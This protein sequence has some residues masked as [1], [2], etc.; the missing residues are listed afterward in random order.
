MR[1]CVVKCVR[2]A[3]LAALTFLA[4]CGTEE[5][6]Y[7][8]VRVTGVVTRNGKP[9]PGARVSFIPAAGNKYST[10]GVDESGP[11]GNYMIKFK[12]RNG[13]AAGKYNVV[14]TPAVELPGNAKIP[15]AFK[16]DPI[17]AQMS[18][19]IGVP[20]MEKKAAAAAAKKEP[21]KQEFDAE[22]EEGASSKQLDFDV[23]G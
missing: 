5:D 2:I 18:L 17:Q 16:D 3:A 12:G 14:V 20:G 13:V 23:K 21:V 10:P 8:L 6:R 1:V 19:G 22:I 7:P 15:E 4:G 11:E 9:L